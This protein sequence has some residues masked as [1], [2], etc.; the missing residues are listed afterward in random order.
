MG[1]FY[2]GIKITDIVVL[3]EHIEQ[4]AEYLSIAFMIE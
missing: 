3:F 2:M 4:K 1:I